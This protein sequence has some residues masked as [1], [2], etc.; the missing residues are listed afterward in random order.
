MIGPCELSLLHSN[1]GCSIAHHRI[2]RPA[3][4]CHFAGVTHC[5]SLI[6]VKSQSKSVVRVNPNIEPVTFS[7]VE[8][9][10]INFNSFEL[11]LQYRIH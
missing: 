3:M 8:R 1:S 11:A 9:A 5:D 10:V 7:F 4:S 2:S 6:R